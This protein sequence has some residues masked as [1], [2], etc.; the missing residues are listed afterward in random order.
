MAKG[1]ALLTLVW[2]Y[3]VHCTV[4][5]GVLEHFHKEVFGSALMFFVSIA[6]LWFPCSGVTKLA[7]QGA[8]CLSSSH[9][10]WANYQTPLVLSFLN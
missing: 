3:R 7:Q 10:K 2:V 8:D 1:W 4:S 9:V 6:M 5:P